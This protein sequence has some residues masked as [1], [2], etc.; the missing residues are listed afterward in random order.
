[1]HVPLARLCCGC[2]GR[3]ICRGTDCAHCALVLVVVCVV[4]CSVCAD[5]FF[6]KRS[7]GGLAM[8]GARGVRGWH[9]AISAAVYGSMSTRCAAHLCYGYARGACNIDNSVPQACSPLYLML[10]C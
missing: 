5:R 4:V 8:A 6:T 2:A 7:A 1:M 10:V 9:T 3:R